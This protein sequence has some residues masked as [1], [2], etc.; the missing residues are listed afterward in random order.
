VYHIAIFKK[1]DVMHCLAAN[2][3]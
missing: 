2:M 1:T 3:S